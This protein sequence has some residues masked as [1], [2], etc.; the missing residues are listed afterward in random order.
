MYNSYVR[1]E[2]AKQTLAKFDEALQM[3]FSTIVRD[4]AIQ[5]FKFS[6]EAIWKA[7]QNYLLVKEGVEVNSP[8]QVIRGCFK[9]NLL[10]EQQTTV[11]LKMIDDRN[12][13]VHLYDEDLA[14]QIF[15]RLKKY[16]QFMHALLDRFK[17][18]LSS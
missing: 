16:N 8:K 2:A 13:T 1:I 15:N 3:S 6:V 9:V 17:N 4:A 10:D 12:L 7:A 18:K 5:R 11:G 14:Q